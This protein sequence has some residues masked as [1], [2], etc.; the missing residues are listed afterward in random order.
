M[1]NS[2]SPWIHSSKLT[3]VVVVAAAAATVVVVT[4]MEAE[5]ALGVPVRGV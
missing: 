3:T 4:T 5:N 2:S 1:E